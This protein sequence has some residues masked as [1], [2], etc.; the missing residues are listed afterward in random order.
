MYSRQLLPGPK[1]TQL[2]LKVKRH[3]YEG[4]GWEKLTGPAMLDVTET[5][6]QLSL[7]TF[8]RGKI[9]DMITE[10]IFGS[11]FSPIEPDLAK[12]MIQFNDDA[13]MVLFH[14][15]AFMAPKLT[16]ARRT[17]EDAFK[18]YIKL[19]REQ[20]AD[21]VWGMQNI[22]AAQEQAGLEEKDRVALLLLVYWAAGSNAVNA[23]FGM[24]TCMIFYAEL[25]KQI[26][27]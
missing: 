23:L 6:M 25:R 10:Y 7:K 2:S 18:K 27:G 13:W 21:A 3:I 26:R 5:H 1:L 22:I 9:I 20:R 14:Y 24:T 15:L 17:V 8:C 11:V 19:P 12:H 4:L 16:R